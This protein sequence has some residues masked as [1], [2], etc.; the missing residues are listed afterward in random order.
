MAVVIQKKKTETKVLAPS[1][2]EE[3]A[4]ITEKVDLLG[5]M[6]RDMDSL[7][8]KLKNDPIAKLLAE[9]KS[10][11]DTL[12]KSIVEEAT[13]NM[14]PNESVEVVG[15]ESKLIVGKKAKK[16]TVTDV[17]GI[18]EY[19]GDEVFFKLA[20]VTLGNV[21]KYLTPSQVESVVET[22]QNGARSVRLKEV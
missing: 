6:K 14:E 3:S 18:Y 15:T 11:F 10:S 7:A 2:P 20:T 1:I 16:R 4:S 22:S 8:A 19:L 9:T 12:K 21:D 17:A 5:Q 13:A